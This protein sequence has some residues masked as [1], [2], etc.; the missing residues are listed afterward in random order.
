MDCYNHDPRRADPLYFIASHYYENNNTQIA[1]KWFKKCFV[2][3]FPVNV[4]I[5]LRPNIYNKFVPQMLTQLCY[6]MGDYKL[7]QQAAKKYL[8]YNEEDNTIL[9]WL[10][11]YNLLVHYPLNARTQLSPGRKKL[12]FVAD[13]GFKSWSGRSILTEGVGGS[14]TYII[15]MSRQF[16]NII[17]YD[18]YVFCDCNKEE[19]FEGV[20]YVDINK[21][22]EFISMH[23]VDTAIISRYPEFIPVSEKNGIKNI[24]LV[25]HDTLPVCN[26]IP[27]TDALKGIYCLTEW[28]KELFL[29]WLPAFKDK[30]FVFPNGINIDQYVTTT[31]N[32]LNALRPL[33]FM[34]SS[35]ANRGLLHLLR[36]F[37][38]IRKHF[39][40][41]VLHI[42]CD[43]KNEWIRSLDPVDMNEI[44]Q[45]VKQYSSYVFSHGFVPKSTLRRY[46]LDADVWLY[47]CIFPETFCITALEAAASNTLAIASDLSALKET[48]GDRGILIPGDPRSDVWQDEAIQTLVNIFDSNNRSKRVDLINRNKQWADIHDWSQLAKRFTVLIDAD[49]LQSDNGGMLNWSHNIPEGSKQIFQN[50]LSH[51]ISYKKCAILEIGTYTGVSIIAMLNYLSNAHGT[52]IDLWEDY[53]ETKMLQNITT[54]KI[55]HI[56]HKNVRLSCMEDRITSI[57]GDSKDILMRFITNKKS[58]DFIYVDGSHMCL[59][60]YTDLILSWKILN[61]NGILAIDDYLWSLSSNNILDKPY[62][63]VQ[64]FMKEY[65][66]TYKLLHT[67]Y[68]VFLRKIT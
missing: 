11:I 10:K 19:I 25:I 66:G 9:S 27:I 26:I 54:N 44:D 51:F 41:S 33:V 50:M 17:D 7:G 5:S 40:G 16:C 20:H 6:S 3:G 61:M 59:D 38:K 58:F 64:H 30:T 23:D 67:G 36:M 28:H 32:T 47:P 12:C 15:E 35:L 24:H 46:W 48:V 14:E 31:V 22:M 2:L 65:K 34:Y 56:F 62:H 39:P 1:F 37:P 57:R 55:E 4:N 53:A 49:S 43:M 13:G 52:T 68:R 42:F 18:I 21:Y 45:L 63:A 8:K 60:C 29:Q